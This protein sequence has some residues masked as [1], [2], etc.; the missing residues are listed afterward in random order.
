MR[1]ATKYLAKVA[2]SHSL[3]ATLLADEK[4][5]ELPPATMREATRIFEKLAKVSSEAQA[6][7]SSTG[8]LRYSVADMGETIATAKSLSTLVHGLLAAVRKHKA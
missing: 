2:A 8:H 1:T 6:V 3:M 5:S 7:V 4:R